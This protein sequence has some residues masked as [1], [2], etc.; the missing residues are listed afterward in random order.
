MLQGDSGGPLMIYDSNEKLTMAGE[1]CVK[2]YYLLDFI[3]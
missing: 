2:C 1:C 3:R